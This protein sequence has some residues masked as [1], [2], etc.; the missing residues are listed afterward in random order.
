MLFKARYLK[1]VFFQTDNYPYI[2]RQAPE[3]FPAGSEKHI[4]FECKTYMFWLQKTYVLWSKYLCFCRQILKYFHPNMHC[5]LSGQ[6]DCKSTFWKQ[7]KAERC[8]W[9]KPQDK[10]YFLNL[11][12]RTLILQ[13]SHCQIIKK[14]VNLSCFWWTLFY[15]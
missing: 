6:N 13:N 5:F 12:F 3:P 7:L 9:N 2:H 10:H 14:A 4:C 15:N 8:I 1:A 11:K